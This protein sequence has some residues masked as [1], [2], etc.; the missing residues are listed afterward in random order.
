MTEKVQTT[1]LSNEALNEE[2]ISGK[3]TEGSDVDNTIEKPVLKRGKKERSPA[4]QEAFKRLLEKNRLRR[5]NEAKIKQKMEA[6]HTK[7]VKKQKKKIVVEDSSDSSST[8]DY[9]IEVRKKTRK[10]KVEKK[11]I[12]QQPQLQYLEPQYNISFL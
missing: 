7:M 11:P 4:Q 9:E 8:S 6:Q 5:E 1:N 12:P 3:T 2:N 10:T